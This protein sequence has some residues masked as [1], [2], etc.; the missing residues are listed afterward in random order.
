MKKSSEVAKAKRLGLF[1]IGERSLRESTIQKAIE[2]QN[3]L[4]QRDKEREHREKK[5]RE[6]E[7]SR[8]PHCGSRI[9]YQNV[10]ALADTLYDGNGFIRATQED[11]CDCLDVR[12]PGCHFPCL[13]CRSQKCGLQCRVNRTWSFDSIGKEF[14]GVFVKE[15]EKPPNYDVRNETAKDQQ[16]KAANDKKAA[17]DKKA[18]HGKNA[19][20]GNSATRQSK[21]RG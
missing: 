7:E 10:F 21:R 9:D 3:K 20:N 5:R 15:L 14:Y 6:D 19:A 12:C 1:S 18:V 2:T 13:K 4:E 17:D 16:M 11:L 8:K